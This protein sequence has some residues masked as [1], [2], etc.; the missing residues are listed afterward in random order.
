MR[1]IFGAVLAAG[2]AALAAA[3]GA[4]GHGHDVQHGAL[5]IVE[6]FARASAGR[7]NVGA[8]FMSIENT[9]PTDRL[10]A[11]RAE[12]SETVE[13]HTH[14]MVGE[15]MQMRKVEAIEV[16]GGG[17][18]KLAPGGLHVMFIGLKAPLGEG[19]S[20]PAT[21]VFEKAGEVTIRFPVARV[22]AMAP[23]AKH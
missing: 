17:T 16:T 2:L 21:L 20:F 3:G 8:G 9:G 14:T 23:A 7:A 19:Q 13:L 22:G 5:T 15:V 12:V 1:P 4:L 6:P 11:V 18:T 10:I